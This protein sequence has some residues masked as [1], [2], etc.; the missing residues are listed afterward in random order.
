ML[1]NTY[2]P[3]QTPE[4]IVT[5][6]SVDLEIQDLH[7]DCDMTD[8][9]EGMGFGLAGWIATERESTMDVGRAGIRG[10]ERSVVKIS[11]SDINCDTKGETAFKECPIPCPSFSS[12]FSETVRPMPAAENNMYLVHEPHLNA[13]GSR[14]STTR[15]RKRKTFSSNQ[16]MNNAFN[17]EP[18]Q[19]HFIN[20]ERAQ[21]MAAHFCVTSS[22]EYAKKT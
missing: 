4:G 10:L 17:T 9:F 21:I 7:A 2:P 20:P 15:K 5:A 6:Q 8:A 3:S 22:A 11:K 18:E 1:N 12:A 14:G 19:A 16:S 13:N